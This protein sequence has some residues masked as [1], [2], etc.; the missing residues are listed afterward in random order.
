MLTE[1]HYIQGLVILH[2]VYGIP[3]LNSHVIPEPQRRQEFYQRVFRNYLEITQMH[4]SFYN[5]LL[6]KK[7]RSAPL[8][9][10]IGSTLL[11]HVTRLMEPYII[12]TS[13]HIRALHTVSI[14]VRHNLHFSKFLEKQ[15]TV[16]FTG[17]LGF[18]HYLTAPTQWI[19][20]F[21]LMVEA[22]LKYTE[23][24]GDELALN[25]SLSLMHDILCCMN[26]KMQEKHVIQL[27]FRLYPSNNV[28]QLPTNTKLLFEQ[29]VRLIR[30]DNP[31]QSFNCHLFLFSHALILTYSKVTRE[32]TSYIVVPGFPIPVQMVSIHSDTSLSLIRRISQSGFL[33]GIRRH[34]SMDLVKGNSQFLGPVQQQIKTKLSSIKARRFPIVSTVTPVAF[35]ETITVSRRKPT[36]VSSVPFTQIKGNASTFDHSVDISIKRRTLTI[37]H[38]ANSQYTFKLEFSYQAQ[39]ANWQTRIR[40]AVIDSAQYAP[41]KPVKLELEKHCMHSLLSACDFSTYF[42]KKGHTEKLIHLFKQ[43][44]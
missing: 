38:L 5:A 29:A 22:I 18:H 35:T 43:V 20:K 1:Q 14:E 36:S 2:T 40:Q 13:S 25:V 21:K 19:G 6:S 39:K 16:K 17:R 33:N 10:R 42:K 34:R 32:R 23:D 15:D 24:D 8:I 41:F 3:L 12:Y 44:T 9:G 31:L 28:L 7:R 27:D 11:Q 30:P 4:H 26:S 37:S